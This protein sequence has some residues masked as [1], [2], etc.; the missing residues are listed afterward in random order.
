MS[1]EGQ[2]LGASTIAGGGA[3]GVSALVNTGNPAIVGIV[4]GVAVIVILGFVV[5]ATQ[6]G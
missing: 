3:A 4:A 5:R 1:V 6:R 2:V